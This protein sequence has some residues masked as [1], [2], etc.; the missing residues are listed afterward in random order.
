VHVIK[1]KGRLRKWP[2][3]ETFKKTWK[4]NT[5]SN[6]RLDPELEEEIWGSKYLML[7][8]EGESVM[9]CATY[10]LPWTERYP[11]IQCDVTWRWDFRR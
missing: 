7:K 11:K 10:C 4:P 3:I 2:R 6:P 1:D 8:D 9:M 5:M